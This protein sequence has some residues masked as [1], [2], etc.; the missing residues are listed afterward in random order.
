MAVGFGF[1][2]HR[3][4]PGRRLMLGGVEIDHPF[5]ALGHSDGDVLLHALI[6]AL[7]GA[8]GEGDIGQRFPDDDPKW[9]DI[10]SGVLLNKVA[11]DLS[12]KG[13]IVN[14][15]LTLLAEEPK[16]SPY[17]ER[18]R[19]RVAELLRIKPVQVNV[20]AKTME[21][22]GPIGAREAIGAIAAVQLE[23]TGNR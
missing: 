6:D 8:A 13:R 4:V 1:D 19:S 20:K 5:G 18:I 23:R 12:K 2:L 16:L 3:L 10:E 9:K 22:L 14:A 17:Q 15:D 21:G 11:D 7:L